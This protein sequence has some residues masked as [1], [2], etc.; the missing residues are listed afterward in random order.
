MVVIRCSVSSSRWW[1]FP[2][3]AEQ[4]RHPFQRAWA[5]RSHAGGVGQG[6]EQQPDDPQAWPL[7]AAA[8][9]LPPDR[10]LQPGQP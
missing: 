2:P 4:Q 6:G 8:G 9:D 5:V 7:S 1:G 10:G 3:V